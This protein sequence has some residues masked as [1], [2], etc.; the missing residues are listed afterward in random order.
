MVKARVVKLG[1]WLVVLGAM[2]A[3]LVQAAPLPDGSRV[4]FLG[5]SI[6]EQRMYT[7][8]VMDYFAL[9]YPDRK[10]TFRNAGWGGGTAIEG[11]E[12]LERDVLSQQPTLV[13]ICFGMNDGAYTSFEQARYDEF[14]GAM[15]GLVQTLKGK[16]V[17]VVLLTP[18]AV[19]EEQATGEWKYNPTMARYAEGVVGLAAQEQVPVYNIHT[20]MFEAQAKAKQDQPGYTMIPDT[21][22]P[23]APGHAVMAYGLLLAMGAA[24]PAAS[25]SINAMTEEAVADRAVVTELVA[26]A[27]AVTFSRVDRAL[28]TY[29]DPGAETMYP[30]VPIQETLNKYPF[31]VSGLTGGKW[32]LTVEGE[33]VGTFSAAELAQGIDLGG[34]PGPWRTLGEQVDATVRVQETLYRTRWKHLQVLLE[35]PEAA[36][37][38]K[39]ALERKLDESIAE[40]EAARQQL[41]APK[42]WRWSLRR[43]Q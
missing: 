28:P 41:I 20:L 9:R 17:Q 11:L 40:Q 24:R 23:S 37:P 36:Q 10:I 13:T 31:Q 1:L 22:H 19:D 30:Y 25:V 21:V 29:F 12:R 3:G 18:G 35:V 27:E 2:A 34:A 6:T 7:R 8:Y 38:E 4:V 5:D 42:A 33:E 26:T 43:V 16:G 14:M 15:T 32:K 39:L